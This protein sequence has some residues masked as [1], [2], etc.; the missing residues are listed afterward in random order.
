[1]TFEDGRR[2]AGRDPAGGRTFD[3]DMLNRPAL[4]GSVAGRI[5]EEGPYLGPRGITGLVQLNQRA[6]FTKD[7]RERYELYYAK[8]QSLFLDVEILVKALLQLLRR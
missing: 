4:D 2:F 1:L 5:A 6:G 7:E 8:N 3:A